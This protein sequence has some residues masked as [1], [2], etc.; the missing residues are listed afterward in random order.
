[1]PLFK[2]RTLVLELKGRLI[3]EF[4]P[5]ADGFY[6][7]VAPFVLSVRKKSVLHVRVRSDAPVDVAVTGGSGA[8]LAHRGRV[9]DASFEVETGG[10][11]EMSAIFG[12]F[13]GEK[14]TIDAEIWMEKR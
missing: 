5:S 6:R 11:S 7:N 13:A 3:G 12:V 4:D 2:K 9:T 8:P 1:V 14:A 10:D